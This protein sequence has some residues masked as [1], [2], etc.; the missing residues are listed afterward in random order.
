MKL[1]ACSPALLVIF[2]GTGDLSVRK[3]LPALGRLMVERSISSRCRIIAT[4]RNATYDDDAFREMA[5]AALTE[6]GL[7]ADAIPPGQLFYQALGKQSAADYE[8]LAKRV[9]TIRDEGDLPPNVV[10][11]LA[12]PPQAFAPTVAAL[13][14]AGLNRVQGDGFTRLVVEKP[15]GHDLAS[16]QVLNRALREHFGEDQIFRIDH[17]LGK[18]PVQ[19]LLAFR[20]SNGPLESLWNRTHIEAVEISAYET[21]GVGRRAGYYDRSGALRDMVQNHLTQL[22][23]LVA[24]EPPTSLEADAIRQEKVKVLH[25]LVPLAEGDVIRGRYATGQVEGASVPDYLAED[26]VADN[27][28]TETFVAARAEVDNW[29]WSGVPFY[30]RTGK[31]MPVRSTE[32][33]LLFRAS[34][35]RLYRRDEGQSVLRIRLQPDEGFS[36]SL[37]VKRPGSAADLESIPLGFRYQDKF[38]TM[39]EAYQTLL[40]DVLS[41][42]Q[43]LFV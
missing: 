9:A 18:D 6:R 37:N 16:A 39:P 31:R 3:L 40:H 26:G 17:Y 36:W 5:A 23:T 21:L 4:G 20:L 42:D 1:S 13:G 43:T 2:G 33:A 24:M 11:Y 29:R 12:L 8:A 19:N 32:I 38:E 10:F 30:L 27:S 14:A 25:S 7:A 22:F 41:G 35:G 34:P 28:T 15:L